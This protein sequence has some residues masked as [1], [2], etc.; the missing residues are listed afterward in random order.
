MVLV[1]S[2]SLDS[3]IRDFDAE[4]QPSNPDHSSRLGMQFVR[5]S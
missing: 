3:G 4:G 1:S 2:F 5:P